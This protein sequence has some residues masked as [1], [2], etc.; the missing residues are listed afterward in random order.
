MP[1]CDD[2]QRHGRCCHA[3]C[4]VLTSASCSLEDR[5]KYNSSKIVTQLRLKTATKIKILKTLGHYNN[6][7]IMPDTLDTVYAKLLLG[8]IS[9]V[10]DNLNAPGVISFQTPH[11]T[12]YLPRARIESSVALSPKTP[13]PSSNLLR[14]ANPAE[15]VDRGGQN[16]V[17]HFHTSLFKGFRT[18]D[19][20]ETSHPPKRK[21]RRSLIPQQEV[22]PL[23]RTK[24]AAKN[25]CNS[26]LEQ[27]QI[28]LT[29]RLIQEASCAYAVANL[30]IFARF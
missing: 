3:S 29:S 6:C 21:H 9:I 12:S 28:A 20:S 1:P 22:V 10:N 14:L 30:P 7:Q 2:K 24:L 13:R 27:K 26:E 4:F 18:F 25:V 19:R 8:I 23:R 16:K 17:E 15:M 5:I 11:Q